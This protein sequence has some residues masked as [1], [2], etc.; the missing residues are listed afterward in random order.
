MTEM[1]SPYFQ[2][3]AERASVECQSTIE[4]LATELKLLIITSLPDT[5]S[6]INL[7]LT[8]PEFCGTI[9]GYEGEIAKTAVRSAIDEP[10]MPFAT[11]VYELEALRPRL[12]RAFADGRGHKPELGSAA[13][14]P[15]I[16]ILD[17]HFCSE[18]ART[19]YLQSE[20]TKLSVASRYLEFF[21][22]ARDR[23]QD[24]AAMAM[25][26]A[27]AYRSTQ[28]GHKGYS[29]TPNYTEV[30]RV[31]K[32]LY[33]FQ[34]V[35]TVFPWEAFLNDKHA[36][37]WERFCQQFSPWEMEQARTVQFLLIMESLI[38]ILRFAL[39]TPRGH[40]RLRNLYGVVLSQGVV[41]RSLCWGE[42]EV[43]KFD[44]AFRLAREFAREF[45]PRKLVFSPQLDVGKFQDIS[46]LT[47]NLNAEPIFQLYPEDDS[48]PKAWW[49]YRFIERHLK[50]ENLDWKREPWAR[51]DA[52]L[53]Q[54]G[55][56]FW[57]WETLGK[58]GNS[59]EN[60]FYD[61]DE[62]LHAAEGCGSA[63][64]PRE[65]IDLTLK[66]QVS[67]YLCYCRCP[68]DTWWELEYW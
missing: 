49:Y 39:N 57:D 53:S 59:G 11:A 25:T 23:A 26:H 16:D 30:M 60:R 35:S 5:S 45:V 46:P 56:V 17:R 54:R 27:C 41:K 47:V 66:N 61:T 2:A 44:K 58:L 52:C 34:L 64:W 10:L 37:G 48:G 51:C 31:C 6:I 40:A 14:D 36:E 28:H 67:T 15:A 33:L 50:D 9:F 63:S 19:R 18:N 43:R 8:G 3:A 62:L 55:Y 21:V 4:R 13:F 22:T 29:L 12:P 65:I 24:L 20:V 1:Q 38:G 32:T 7:A 42:V 68:E